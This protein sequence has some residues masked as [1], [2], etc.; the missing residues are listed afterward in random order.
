VVVLDSTTI[1]EN[2]PT[3]TLATIQHKTAHVQL[4]LGESA[5]S[6]YLAELISSSGEVV[7]SEAEIPVD[8][9]ADRVGFDIPAEHLT[10]GDFQIKLTRIS[11]GKQ[12]IYFLRVR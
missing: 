10:A 2:A 9:N 12:A 5:S 7:L 11:D 4:L 1:A 3:V 6:R 8:A